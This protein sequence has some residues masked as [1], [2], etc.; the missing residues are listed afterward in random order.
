MNNAQTTG[1]PKTLFR[2]AGAGASLAFGAMVG[3][4]FALEPTPAGLLF[5]LN[6]S[7]V[8]AFIIAALFAWMYWR[9]VE[10]MALEKAPALRKKKF[11]V[12]SLGLVLVGI[13]SFLYP[14]KFIAPEKRHDVF[15]GLALAVAVLTGVGV[16]M[17][18]VRNFLEAD[19][20]RSEE[21]RHDPD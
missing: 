9:M 21:D 17:W 13:V 12:F 11:I 15:I 16:V 10:R 6:T 18:R 3:T 20:K 5:V 4:L 1:S 19:L 14:M 2:I 7:A 8:V